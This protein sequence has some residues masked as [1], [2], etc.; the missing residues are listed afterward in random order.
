MP[1]KAAMID[2]ISYWLGDIAIASQYLTTPPEPASADKAESASDPLLAA[3]SMLERI[4]GQVAIL[5]GCGIKGVS[6]AF[7]EHLQRLG[8]DVA[9]LGNA[10][11][12][13][14][15]YTNIAYPE[16]PDTQTLANAKALGELCGVPGNLI[17][18][19]RGVTH[20]TI[21]VGKDYDIILNRLKKYK[22]DL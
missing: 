22:R 6:Q 10:K 19:N 2:G 4:K 15:R 1:G 20:A 11:H 16:N 13:D 7:S 9:F 14:Y 8:I 21:I 5:N 18:P 12:F 3:D 17:R